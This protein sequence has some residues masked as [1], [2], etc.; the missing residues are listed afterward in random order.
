MRKSCGT[1]TKVQDHLLVGLTLCM[2]ETGGTSPKG[3]V[4]KP[5]A[6]QAYNGG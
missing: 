2:S 3:E 6:L 4:T 5:Y 1:R